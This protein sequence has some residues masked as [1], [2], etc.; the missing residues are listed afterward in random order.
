[1]PCWSVGLMTFQLDVWVLRPTMCFA[2]VQKR[3][4]RPVTSPHPMIPS[5]MLYLTI[6]RT[7]ISR[8]LMTSVGVCFMCLITSVFSF[9]LPLSTAMCFAQ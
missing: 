5:G 8:V 6:G 7:T 3:L 2:V 1:M 4:F 9:T